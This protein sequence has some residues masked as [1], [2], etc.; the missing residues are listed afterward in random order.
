MEYAKCKCS[1]CGKV[2]IVDTDEAEFECE[3]CNSINEIIYIQE[4]DED[5]NKE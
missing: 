2:N 1:N 3:K 4:L 5:D